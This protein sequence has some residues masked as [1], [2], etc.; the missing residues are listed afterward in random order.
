MIIIFILLFSIFSETVKADFTY[1]FVIEEN[2]INYGIEEASEPSLDNNDQIKDLLVI[3]EKDQSLTILFSVETEDNQAK[4][5]YLNCLSSDRE[6]ELR[7]SNYFFTDLDYQYLGPSHEDQFIFNL[8]D[9]SCS[10]GLFV[11]SKNLALVKSSPSNKK[12]IISY[13]DLDF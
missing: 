8:N 11:Y 3:E 6:I 10:G 9:F 2:A 12:T 7:E 1:E 13:Q 5:Y 4:S